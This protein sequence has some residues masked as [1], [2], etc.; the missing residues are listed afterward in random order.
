[1][2]SLKMSASVFCFQHTFTNPMSTFR[3]K[4]G[5]SFGVPS[6]SKLPLSHCHIYLL[7]QIHIIK[8]SVRLYICTSY[9][10]E[11]YPLVFC[12]AMWN[13]FVSFSLPVFFFFM[14][15]DSPLSTTKTMTYTWTCNFFLGN[16]F[17]LQWTEFT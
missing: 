11:L 2:L 10:H 14:L 16:T 9:S 13:K 15:S 3:L 1:M 8:S 17:A 7:L 4:T 6:E 12:C 5:S